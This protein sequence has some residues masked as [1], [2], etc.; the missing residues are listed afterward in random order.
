MINNEAAVSSSRI[1]L[2]TQYPNSQYSKVVSQPDYFERLQIMYSEQ[3]K[4][5]AETYKAYNIND[6]ATV[7]ANTKMFAEKF[8]LSDL[9]PKFLFLN[10]MSIG[11]TESQEVFEKELT[12]LVEAHPQ[13]DVSV[14]SRDILAL[15]LQGREAKKG[16][17]QGSLLA[18]RNE[19]TT[20]VA[21][22]AANAARAFEINTDT[23]H[24]IVLQGAISD[25]NMNKLMYNLASFNFTRFMVKD[26]DLVR[27]RIDSTTQTLSVTNLESF[28]EAIWY[29]QTIESDPS[30][31]R[32]LQSLNLS[33][34]IIS[35]DN[36]ALTRSGLT[37]AQYQQF[38]AQN[39]SK[40]SKKSFDAKAFDSN[41]APVSKPVAV[42]PPNVAKPAESAQNIVQDNKRVVE[43]QQQQTVQPAP[44]VPVAKT[45][46]TTVTPVE[47][48][49]TPLFKNLYA[50]KPNDPHYVTVN[51]LSGNFDAQQLKTVFENYN[52]TNYAVLNLKLN[53]EDSG[54]Q[55]VLIIGSFADANIAKSYLLRMVR[56]AELFVPLKGCDYRN[57]VGTQRNFNTMMSQNAMPVY[58]EF[59]REFYLK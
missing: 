41:V 6:F 51:V 4:L 48:D 49:D 50:Y 17:S 38:F 30:L 36:Y 44:Q 16:G 33:K 37:I 52:K 55:K 7:K 13:S 5:Y 20:S 32:I 59:M 25:D 26:F 8:P 10:A 23:K 24:R 27:L 11:K 53:L 22:D 34:I 31:S 54:S 15:M 21:V 3:D 28:D 18:R 14:M 39:L 9:L 2:L 35:E 56:E 43:Q 40:F 45:S 1:I 42:A 58:I 47:I 12:K 57:L 46:P 19:S 29:T